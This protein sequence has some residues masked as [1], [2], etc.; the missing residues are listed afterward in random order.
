[1]EVVTGVIGEFPGQ[2]Q[3]GFVIRKS[4]AQ[5]LQAALRFTQAA[6]SGET[7]DGIELSRLRPGWSF[8]HGGEKTKKICGGAFCTFAGAA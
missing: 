4:A 2:G 1:M 7:V 3:Q 8:F 5:R 6:L